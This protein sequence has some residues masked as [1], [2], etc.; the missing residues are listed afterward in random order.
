MPL[1]GHLREL[2]RRLVVSVFAVLVG[3]IVGWIIYPQAFDFLKQPYVDGIQPLLDRKGF[4]SD[5][6]LNGGVGSAFSFRLKL[7]LSIGLV[8]SSPV[9]IGQ[10]WGFILP[11][12]HRNEKHWAFL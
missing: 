1:V 6:V 3:T 12:L 8:I 4:Q 9:W 10:I 2:R 11:A 5:L 7:A